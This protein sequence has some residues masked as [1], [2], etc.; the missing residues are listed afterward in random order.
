MLLGILFT[1]F[2]FGEEKKQIATWE[3]LWTN[4][5]RFTK[6]QKDYGVLKLRHSNQLI[7]IK[8]SAGPFQGAHDSRI[9]WQGS[10]FLF[11]KIKKQTIEGFTV[12]SGEINRDELTLQTV[13]WYDNG[14][15]Q[16]TEEW[17]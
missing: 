15:I 16:T 7:Y 6:T 9:C 2:Q 17:E 8:P 12:Y 10:G 13:W 3:Y 11:K 1:G 14:S 5:D 4:L